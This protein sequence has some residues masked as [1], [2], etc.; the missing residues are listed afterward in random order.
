[1]FFNELRQRN[2]RL[3]GFFRTLFWIDGD[4]VEVFAGGVDGD[5]FTAG[6]QAGVDADDRLFAVRRGQQEAPQIFGEDFDGGTVGLHFH[7]NGDVDFDAERQHP[8]VGILNGFFEFRRERRSRI[9]IA[10]FLHLLDL[11]VGVDYQLATQ[12][13]FGFTAA[14]RQIAV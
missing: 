3:L 9:Q 12:L 8:L 14:D 1:M 7:F 4:G 5:A 11:L 13:A 6:A 2:L 10:E